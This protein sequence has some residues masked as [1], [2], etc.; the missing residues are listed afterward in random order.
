MAHTKS[1]SFQVDVLP[2]QRKQLSLT[3]TGT[4]C[5]DIHRVEAIADSCFDEPACLVRLDRPD[6][7]TPDTRW[8]DELGDVARCE[9]PPFGRHKRSTQD[10]V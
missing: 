6:L 4:E 8:I 2:A 9:S 7:V 1:A 5:R 10:S 3:E